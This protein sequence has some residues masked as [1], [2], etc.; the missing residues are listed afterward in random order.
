MNKE[1]F[2]QNEWNHLHDCIFYVTGKKSS[3]E[4]L[5]KFFD[6]LPENLQNEAIEWGMNDTL[7]RDNLIK[8]MESKI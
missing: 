6:L 7:W 3:Q 5:E 4:K 1:N 2:T 8:W